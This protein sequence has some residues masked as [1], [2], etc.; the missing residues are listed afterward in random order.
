MGLYNEAN[1]AA[2]ERI[3]AMLFEKWIGASDTT[4]A[5]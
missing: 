3:R 2:L 5:E 1:A 4:V